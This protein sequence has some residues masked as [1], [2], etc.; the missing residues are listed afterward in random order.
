MTDS[1]K[2][3]ELERFETK[4]SQ[5][6]WYTLD[7][8]EINFEPAKI[9]FGREVPKERAWFDELFD[10]GLL[11]PGKEG[12]PISFLITGPPGS[13]KT[14]LALELCY[15][16]AESKLSSLYISLEAETEQL[17][18]NAARFGYENIHERLLRFKGRR[19]EISAVAIWGK[20]EIKEWKTLSEIVGAAIEGVKNRLLG[21]VKTPEEVNK[22]WFKIRW[23]TTTN[24]IEKI[25][26]H[27]LVIDS[28]NIVE[29]V[30]RKEFFEQFLAIESEGTKLV[31][32][33]LDSAPSDAE[34][35]FWEY[36]CDT[37]V[38]LD[39]TTVEDYYFR[40]IEVVKARYQSHIW[41]KQQLKVYPKL[42]L[43]VPSSNKRE[44]E[45]LRRAHPYRNEGGVFI[46][47]SIHYYLSVYKRLGHEQRPEPSD[48]YP[49]ELNKILGLRREAGEGGIPEGRCTAFVGR[50]GGHKS[51]LGFLHLLHRIIN[52]K[53]TGLV[54]SLRDDEEM[55]KLTMEN[56]LRQ[57]FPKKTSTLDDFI[58]RDQ[59]E[60][61][62]Y[63]PGYITPEEFFHR[64][65]ISVHRLK[66]NEKKLTVVFNSLDQLSARFPLCAKQQI[67]VPGIIE[68]LSGERATS[69]FIGVD[70]PGQPVQQY[71]LLPM[72]DLILS[73]NPY[74]FKFK[75]YYSHLAEA[76]RLRDKDKQYQTKIERIRIQSEESDREEVVLQVI[77]SAGGQRA[78]ARGLLELVDEDKLGVS[79]YKSAGLHFT[80]LSPK[81]SHG[82]PIS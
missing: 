53:E 76:G 40:T 41:G 37:V 11:L 12:K 27:I 36:V 74:H 57:Q 2:K 30:H 73:F 38:R 45:K 49:P 22:F 20:E 62:Y 46:Y 43:T 58:E 82:K 77:R 56:I 78:G 42:S 9:G 51:H 81:I 10:G 75:D 48:T 67:F 63:H 68:T 26:P 21:S 25:S 14:T 32:F 71:G 34:H 4:V 23:N 80:E 33:I 31:I 59:L 29:A 35:R 39:Y 13:C 18:D 16:L 1:S 3:V 65:F 5:A 28:L 54:I 61:L 52:R 70:E 60:I 15:R 19:T 55:T 44:H 66:R 64:M 69:I 50:R 8:T 47:P 7:K 24:Q 6:F 79:L 72:A 17:K